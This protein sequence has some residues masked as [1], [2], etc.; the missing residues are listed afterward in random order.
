[1]EVVHIGTVA[2]VHDMVVS[3]RLLVQ[4]QWEV[5]KMDGIGN[6]LHYFYSTS[7]NLLRF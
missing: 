3:P 5:G 4:I 6:L 7:G 1:M 2:P